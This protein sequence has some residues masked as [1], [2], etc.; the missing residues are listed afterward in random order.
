V[1]RT[2]SLDARQPSWSS[3]TGELEQAIACGRVALTGAR[4]RHRAAAR[5]LGFLHKKGSFTATWRRTTSCSPATRTTASLIDLGIAR[6]A[7]VRSCSPSLAA[8][9]KLR[10]SPEAFGPP[11]RRTGRPQAPLLAGVVFLRLLTGRPIV[12]EERAAWS[13]DTCS[14]LRGRSDPEGRISGLP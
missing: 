12:G 3:S 5:A 10:Y 7:A 11:H 6:S 8:S 4:C 14:T 9:S 13:R 1:L 2:N